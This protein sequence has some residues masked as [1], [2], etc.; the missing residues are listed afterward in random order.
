M[1]I[2]ISTPGG[3]LKAFSV[4]GSLHTEVQRAHFYIPLH[5]RSNK[6]GKLQ[7]TPPFAKVPCITTVG[8]YTGSYEPRIFLKRSLLAPWG[9]SGLRAGIFPVRKS[10]RWSYLKVLKGHLL[11]L[12]SYMYQ[13]ICA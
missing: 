6:L 9:L 4:Y 10:V 7:K 5:V 3:G 8:M 12:F 2:G 1:E 11:Q 13:E